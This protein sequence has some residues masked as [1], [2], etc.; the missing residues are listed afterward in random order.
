MLEQSDETH[1]TA[2]LQLHKRLLARHLY[3]VMNNTLTFSDIRLFEVMA[4]MIDLLLSRAAMPS[5]IPIAFLRVRPTS[6]SGA[7]TPRQQPLNAFRTPTLLKR[8]A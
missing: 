1:E 3:N 6:Q 2:I 5:N 4:S 8:I 7:P